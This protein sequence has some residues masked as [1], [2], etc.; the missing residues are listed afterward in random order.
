MV[1]PPPLEFAL[2]PAPSSLPR[3]ES[4]H[5]PRLRQAFSLT[6]APVRRETGLSLL[7]GSRFVLDCLTQGAPVV[8]VFLDEGL[9]PE[10]FGQ[11]TEAA[12]SARAEVF[13]VARGLLQ[14]LSGQEAAEGAAATVRI[15]ELRL[16]KV[17][18]LSPLLVCYALQNPGNLGAVVRA[19]A[20][21]GA[22]AVVETEG[23]DPYG[24]KALRG[25][26]GATFAIPVVRWT[27]GLEALCETLRSRDYRLFAADPHQGRAHTQLR[28]LS[29]PVTLLLGSE[30][31][32]FDRMFLDWKHP[33]ERVNIRLRGPVESL[34]VAVA[35]GILLDRLVSDSD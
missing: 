2:N 27:D 7:E 16:E 1:P 21:L 13:R 19:A 10:R 12:R 20:A 17:L 26:A 6:R 24:P 4:P 34:N 3:L 5:N 28:P 22:G 11:L 9:A 14:R 32:G 23:C 29:S 8:E 33:P 31:S 18:G 15:P 35:A 30:G 25:A